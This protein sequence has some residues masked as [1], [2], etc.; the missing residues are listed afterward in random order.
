MV[1]VPKRIFHSYRHKLLVE[2]VAICFADGVA[3]QVNLAQ[4][5]LRA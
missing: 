3:G 2:A 4:Y 1:E 5:L